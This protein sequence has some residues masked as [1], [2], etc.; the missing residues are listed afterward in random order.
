MGK[1]AGEPKTAGNTFDHVRQVF[2]FFLAGNVQ[3]NLPHVG[4]LRIW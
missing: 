3:S 2:F 1:F 4:E